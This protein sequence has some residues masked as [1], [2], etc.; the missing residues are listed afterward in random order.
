VSYLRVYF[1][2]SNGNVVLD[3][4][5]GTERT[6][7]ANVY[8]NCPC[9]GEHGPDDERPRFWMAVFDCRVKMLNNGAALIFKE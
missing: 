3:T 7:V 4:G 9:V 2:R 8:I 6:E 1:E 5:A